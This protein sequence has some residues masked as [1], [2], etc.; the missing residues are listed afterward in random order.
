MCLLHG[1][2]PPSNARLGERLQDLWV[3]ECTKA[4]QVIKCSA[5]FLKKN[6]NNDNNGAEVTAV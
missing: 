3:A 1:S 6:N 5:L 4:F 2:P